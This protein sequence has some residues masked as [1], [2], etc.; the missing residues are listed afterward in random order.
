M[1]RNASRQLNPVLAG[2]F[3]LRTRSDVASGLVQ[4]LEGP[5]GE[6]KCPK[7]GPRA[8][9]GHL[10]LVSWGGPGGADGRKNCPSPSG[11]ATHSIVSIV[12]GVNGP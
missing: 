9:L 2:R 1:S 10:E 4:G 12:N 5:M 3:A 6:V 8:P 7:L 11:S